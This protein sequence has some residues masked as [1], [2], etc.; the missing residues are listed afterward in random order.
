MEKCTMFQDQQTQHA[1][2]PVTR[3]HIEIECDPTH[4]PLTHPW[5]GCGKKRILASTLLRVEL[6]VSAAVGDRPSSLAC[7][8]AV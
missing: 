7:H 8:L 4:H 2:V 3:S 6:S 1:H 5:R